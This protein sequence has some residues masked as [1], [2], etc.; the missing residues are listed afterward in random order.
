M[1][2]N[3]EIFDDR[4]VLIETFRKTLSD[5]DSAAI[6]RLTSNLDVNRYSDTAEVNGVL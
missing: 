1:E 3:K 4:R 6:I 5:C 2:L